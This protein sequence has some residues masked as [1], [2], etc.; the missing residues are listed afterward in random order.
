MKKILKS[1]IMVFVLVTMCTTAM[2]AETTPKEA[3]VIS[4]YTNASKVYNW[5]TLTTLPTDGRL[6][7]SA[8][9]MVYYNVNYPNIRTMLDLRREMNSV[10]TS[11]LTNQILATSRNYK[12]F[13]GGLY[14]SP[15]KFKTNAL[16]GQ[17]TFKLIPLT[18]DT[19]NLQ[20]TTEILEDPLH[21]KNN[22][23]RY[24]TKNFSYV[25]TLV[26]WRFSSFERIK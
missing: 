15:C 25:N 17:S 16:A 13:D 23:V 2:A 10:F 26:G 21:N 7:K 24:E 18:A 5:F 11:D 8:G 6:K 19:L 12:E 9:Y 14:V 3:D 20:I 1:L 4:A 22:V